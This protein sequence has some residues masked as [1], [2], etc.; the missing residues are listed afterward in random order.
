MTP[1]AKILVQECVRELAGIF[2]LEISRK[3]EQNLKKQLSVKKCDRSPKT[4][5][6]PAPPVLSLRRGFDTETAQAGT[7]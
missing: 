3:V 4:H 2:Y 6:S 7:G 5:N 1:S